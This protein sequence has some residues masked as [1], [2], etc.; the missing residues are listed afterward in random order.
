M[1]KQS[2]T[3]RQTNAATVEEYITPTTITTN[4]AAL[5]NAV[6]SAGGVS[7]KLS[8]GSQVFSS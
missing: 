8:C 5:G 4:T 3:L 1:E 2:F 6:T 7:G